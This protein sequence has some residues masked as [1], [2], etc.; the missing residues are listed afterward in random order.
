MGCNFAVLNTSNMEKNPNIQSASNHKRIDPIYH[1][2]LVPASLALIAASILLLILS[3]NR[4][5][6]SIL[7]VMSVLLHLTVFLTRN[8]AKQNQDRIIR[9]EI[10]LRF[11][12]IT[13]HP[14]DPYEQ[15]LT[16]EQILALR[17]ADSEE[18]IEMLRDPQLPEKTPLKIKQSIRNWQPD[19]MRV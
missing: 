10:R 3:E 7:L 14:F 6:G 1:Y 15:T 13:R 18:L 2:V 4:F 19:H 11:Y 8:Y 12:I 9:A 16:P 17:F 5:A